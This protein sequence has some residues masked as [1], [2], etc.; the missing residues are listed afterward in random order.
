[1]SCLGPGLLVVVV[2]CFVSFPLSARTVEKLDYP[3]IWERIDSNSHRIPINY[4]TLPFDLLVED[5]SAKSFLTFIKS[6]E[7]QNHIK[8]ENSC[9]RYCSQYRVGNP[10]DGTGSIVNDCQDVCMAT[11]TL[12][13]RE[14]S[15]EQKYFM[16]FEPFEG[17]VPEATVV[18]HKV[19][20]PEGNSPVNLTSFCYVP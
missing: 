11:F 13:N 17:D 10:Y 18:D 7:G 8:R 6:L 19:P 15:D 5:N 14:T 1:M 4:G 16:V 9:N 12:T 3:G 20:C 2:C